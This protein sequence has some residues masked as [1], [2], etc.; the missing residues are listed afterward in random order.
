[1]SEGGS[2]IRLGSSEAVH[3]S[4]QRI[5]N[6]NTGAMIENENTGA[7]NILLVMGSCVTFGLC[8]LL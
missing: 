2:R 8:G 1:M 7:V 5:E 6:A 4:S 3:S